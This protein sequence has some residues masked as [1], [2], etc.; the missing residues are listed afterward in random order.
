MKR[1]YHII[2]AVPAILLAGAVLS[3]CIY[4]YEEDSERQNT[5]RVNTLA[6]DGTRASSDTDGSDN[7]FMVL[8]WNDIAHLETPSADT[9]WPAPYLAG[10]APQPVSFYEHSVF[11]TRYPYPDPTTPLYATGYAPGNVLK[12]DE[13]YRKLNATADDSETGRYDFL[14]CDVWRDVYKGSQDDPFSQDKNKLYFRH[15]AAKLVFYADRDRNTMENK[16]YVRNVQVTSLYMSIDG[17][18]NYTPM[19][20]PCAFEWQNLDESD[21][22]ESYKKTIAAAKLVNGNQSVASAPKAGYK[23]VDAMPFAGDDANFT[24][25]G[26]AADRVPVYGMHIDSCYVCNKIADG[27]VQTSPT[28][29]IRLKMDISAEMSFDP[30]FPINDGSGSTT[31]DLT[32]T[33]KWKNVPLNGI[34][35]VDKDGNITDAKVHEFKPGNEYRVYIHFYRTGVN[36][37]AIELPWNVGGVHYITIPGGSKPEGQAS[38]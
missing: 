30:N 31:D 34:Y 12:S 35:Q 1:I 38:E 19:Y 36:L 22:T 16:Q 37:V 15:L 18:N 20:T 4:D 17:G 8:F 9:K 2:K 5:I 24:L 32:F 21:F 3:S 26:H 14:G 27:V 13:G 6:V 28:H 11:D 25:H 10:H 7:T 29:H 23:A 33:R